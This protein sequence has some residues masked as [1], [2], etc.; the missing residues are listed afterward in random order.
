MEL[1]S[2]KC[3]SITTSG[4]L[5]GC[6]SVS[7]SYTCLTCG[8]FFSAIIAREKDGIELSACLC[9]CHPWGLSHCS[10]VLAQTSEGK[11]SIS[12]G[13]CRSGHTVLTA[14]RTSD[15]ISFLSENF[16]HGDGPIYASLVPERKAA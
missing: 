9:A 12:C 8:H 16:N 4:E 11:L 10:H 13:V 15:G 6:V 2:I 7:L 14:W 3:T 1:G 5:H